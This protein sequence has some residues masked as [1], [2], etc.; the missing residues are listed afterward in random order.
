MTC[1]GLALSY[2][3]LCVHHL[4][5]RL[6]LCFRAQSSMLT[7]TRS[8]Q[9]T[10]PANDFLKDCIR[11]WEV[12]TDP[13]GFKINIPLITQRKYYYSSRRGLVFFFFELRI[14]NIVAKCVQFSF[15]SK[16]ACLYIYKWSVGRVCHHLITLGLLLQETEDACYCTKGG[17]VWWK[18]NIGGS[19]LNGN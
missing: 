1:K 4:L 13:Q 5:A 6:A 15:S 10:A 14:L 18:K 12:S 9:Q 7:P 2:C 16:K 17:A 3:Q 19:K 8:A 11:L